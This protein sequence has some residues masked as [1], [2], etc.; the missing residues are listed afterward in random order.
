MAR[1]GR[2]VAAGGIVFAILLL[3]GLFVY[4]DRG[5]DMAAPFTEQ[6]AP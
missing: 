4:A 1:I 3:V 2:W 6:K 5:T